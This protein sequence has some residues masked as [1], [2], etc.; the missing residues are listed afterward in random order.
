MQIIGGGGVDGVDGKEGEEGDGGWRRWRK[1]GG[2]EDGGKVESILTA[3]GFEMPLITSVRT[4]MKV[5]TDLKK[6]RR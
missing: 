1:R 2:R 5:A 4:T 3:I 6:A